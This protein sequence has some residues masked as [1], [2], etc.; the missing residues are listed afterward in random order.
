MR[1]IIVSKSRPEIDYSTCPLWYKLDID[2]QY[3]LRTAYK[4]TTGYKRQLIPPGRHPELDLFDAEKE[5]RQ[6]PENSREALR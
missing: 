5:M 6:R 4:R 2:S 3:A 1:E